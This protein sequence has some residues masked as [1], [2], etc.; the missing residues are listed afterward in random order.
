VPTLALSAGLAVG[1]ALLAGSGCSPSSGAAT[2]ET[3]ESA[4]APV[5]SR[6]TAGRPTMKSLER[7]TTQPGRIEAF[8]EAPLYSKAAGYTQEVLVDMGDAV[9]KGQTL[10][11]LWI[12]ELED[13]LEQKEALVAQADAEVKQAESMVDAAKAAVDTSRA[14]IVEVEAGVGRARSDYERW[15][16]EYERI[17]E[18]VAKGSVTK[19]LEEETLNQM[20]SSES[21]QQ[22]AAARVQ[23]AKAGLNESQAN[24]RKSTADQVAA[25]ARL[26]V[27]KADLARTKTMLDYTQI[28]AP[29]NGVIT[30]RSVDTGHY[31]SPANASGSKP[32]MVLARTDEVRVFVDIPELEAPLVD[33]GDP[34]DIRVQ[35]LESHEFGGTVTRTSWSLLEANRSLRAEIDLPNPKGLLRPGMYALVTIRL[36]RRDNAVTLPVTAIVR[37]G[38]DAY[39]CCVDSGKIDRRAVQ[40]GLRSGSDVEV[41]SGLDADHV[42]VLMQADALQQGQRVDVI[43]Q[44]K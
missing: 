40:L 19:K 34:A 30:R 6:V 7:H 25:E 14:R 21:A 22:E 5:A 33:V 16:S 1:I 3:G 10:I 29:F 39:C 24:V 15:K 41:V 27:S 38:R 44:P 8:E 11:K 28:K 35:A 18:L 37:D 2:A 20:R 31:V 17:E 13:E 43:A 9:V 42:V 23:S 36:D 26:R 4:S 32:L 12:P